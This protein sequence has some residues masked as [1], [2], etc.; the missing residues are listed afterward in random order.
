MFCLREMRKCQDPRDAR[1]RWRMACYEG[2]IAALADLR[3]QDRAT[4]GN[5][6][7]PSCICAGS[8]TNDS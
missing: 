2:A 8:G 3:P 7:S 4:N 5:G 1:F 6:A